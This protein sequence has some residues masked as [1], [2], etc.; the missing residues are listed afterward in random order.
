MTNHHTVLALVAILA[1]GG[2][3]RGSEEEAALPAM[4]K[5]RFE[6]EMKTILHDLKLA[7]ETAHTLTGSYL[8][9]QPLQGQYFN[10]PVPETYDLVLSDVSS[11]AYRA[12]I[13]HRA[14]GLSC[15]LEVETG[16][17]RGVPVCG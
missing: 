6:T 13:T 12:V 4:L 17:A 14:S 1:V 2:A 15:R 9:L 10:R 5:T 7:Q 3:C 11:S 8:E 16:E